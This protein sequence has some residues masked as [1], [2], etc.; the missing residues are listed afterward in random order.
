MENKVNIVRFKLKYRSKHFNVAMYAHF[1]MQ[2][3]LKRGPFT[4]Y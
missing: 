1:A 3:V 4:W 2:L